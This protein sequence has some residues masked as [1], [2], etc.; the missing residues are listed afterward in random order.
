MFGIQGMAIWRSNSDERKDIWDEE[1]QMPIDDIQAAHRIRAICRSATDSAEKIAR[2]IDGKDNKHKHE[3]ERY[4]RAARA[5]MEVALKIEDGL[6]RDSSVCQI[7]RLC[8]TA[9]D[10]KTARI[11]FRAVQAE[12]IREDV[13]ME[14]PILRQ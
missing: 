3:A 12:S 13:L 8:V 11:L 9:N 4:E 6:L 5:A 1:V 10:T 7:V 14:H 2:G